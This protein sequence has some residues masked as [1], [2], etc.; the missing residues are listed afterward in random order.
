MTS[1]LGLHIV[2]PRILSDQVDLPTVVV[3]SLTA[4]PRYISSRPSTMSSTSNS[5]S[6]NL[7]SNLA[8][9]TF[10]EPRTSASSSAY[11]S[12]DEAPDAISP[13]TQIITRTGADRTPR[14]S[15]SASTSPKY[16]STFSSHP[17]QGP[18]RPASNPFPSSSRTST[19]IRSRGIDH[20][21][22]ESSEDPSSPDLYPRR[23][24]HRSRL[25]PDNVS[26]H[27]FGHLAVRYSTA[28]IASSRSSSRASFRSELSSDEEV[29]IA[30]YDGGSSPVTFARDLD[31]IDENSPVFHRSFFEPRR[32][33]LP[34]AIPGATS[35]A[36][37]NRSREDSILTIR[38]P[39]RSLDDDLASHSGDDPAAVVPRSEPLTRGDF[40]S[41]E[42]Q[43][44]QEPDA[45]TAGFDLAYV[46]SRKSEGSIHSIRSAAQLS[47]LARNSTSTGEPSSSRPSNTWS[48]G[49]RPSAGTGEDTWL[50]HVHDSATSQWSFSKEKADAQPVPSVSSVRHGRTSYGSIPINMDKAKRTMLPGSQEIW[51][52]GHVGRYRVDRL[53]FK[54]STADPAK[55]PQQRINVRHIPDPFLKGPKTGG[56]SSVIHKHS[57]ATA[58]S[59]FRSYSLF[60]QKRGTSTQPGSRNIHMHTSGG[61]MLAP[62]KVQEQYTSTKTTSK[63]NTHNL[64]EDGSRKVGGNG[65]K[66][67]RAFLEKEKRREKEKEEA[68]KAKAK[69]KEKKKEKKNERGSN[70]AEST[71]SSTTTSSAGSVVNASHII[72]TPARA[73]TSKITFAPAII[74]SKSTTKSLPASGPSSPETSDH[75]SKKRLESD[76]STPIVS[77]TRS[78]QAFGTLDPNDIEHLRRAQKP[79]DSS[80][81]ANR[82]LRRFRG[83]SSRPDSSALPAPPPWINEEHV[84]V[85]HRPQQFLPHVGLLHTQPHKPG[86]KSSAKKRATA[87]D[88]F[89]YVPEDS[90]YMLPP[91]MTAST[92]LVWYVPFEDDG[93]K[94]DHPAKKKAKQSPS[95]SDPNAE[96]NQK[97]VYLNTFHVNARLV[98]YDDLRGTGIRLP[99]DGLAITVEAINYPTAN[100]QESEAKAKTCTA[101]EQDSFP[102]HGLTKLGLVPERR[103]VPLPAASD[104]GLSLRI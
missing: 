91:A 75:P 26:Q 101:E 37:S 83:V 44:Q 43:H 12:D 82:I 84:R 33:S 15:V 48:T 89:D 62:K 22:E 29:E 8:T 14:P 5:S 87:H 73:T 24:L 7:Y 51:R 74:L 68:K 63:L 31:N 52:S 41:L 61:I 45:W 21:D 71:E 60:Q 3:S 76:S 55:A 13:L 72:S 39:S 20:T 9:F 10:G 28:S 81:L 23:V 49:R 35:D 27:T 42:A 59:I 25:L 100:A 77:Q 40:R 90:L 64:L 69:A 67:R 96:T 93:N 98:G 94:S 16:V 6:D 50:K 97:N 80:S 46:L 2:D 56:P 53:V 38:R 79:S 99:S 104:R 18:G 86:T 95:T 36:V 30:S 66:S 34:M 78:Y 92:L 1:S 47:F 57:R 58:F 32:G 4:P 88:I 17:S 102:T 85:P 11:D 54:P 70:P 65:D 19:S 103:K